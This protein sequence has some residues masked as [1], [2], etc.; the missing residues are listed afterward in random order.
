MSF[1]T[2]KNCF[3]VRKM[4]KQVYLREGCHPLKVALLPWIQLPL[5]IILSLALRNMSGAFPGSEPSGNV[6]DK[7]MYYDYFY[8]CNID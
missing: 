4:A 5:W 1:L 8:S 2:N 7:V 3:K 6:V